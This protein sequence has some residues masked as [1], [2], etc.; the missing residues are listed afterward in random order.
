MLPDSVGSIFDLMTTS[1]TEF[2]VCL[3]KVHER[4][5]ESEAEAGAQ[6][7]CVVTLRPFAVITEEQVAL[8]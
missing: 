8:R 6:I 2:G 4:G 5:S 7:L 1:L 3:T